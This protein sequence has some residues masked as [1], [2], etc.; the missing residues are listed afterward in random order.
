M[1]H[2]ENSPIRVLYVEDEKD[3]RTAV[4]EILTVFGYE[5][6][7]AENGQLGVE[8]ALAWKPDFILMDVRMPV[9]TGPEA[10]RAIRTYPEMAN[11][12]IFTLTAHTDANTLADCEDAGAD[13]SFA[14][15]PSFGYIDTVIKDTLKQRSLIASS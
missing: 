9:M 5:V 4:A 11:T 3:V 15:P 13:G 2:T 1:T 12:P 7:T 6:K 8:K 14:K 10:I